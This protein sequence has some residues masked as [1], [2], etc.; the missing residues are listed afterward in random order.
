MSINLF[1]SL[2]FKKEDFL[3]Y[4]IETIPIEFN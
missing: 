1:G 4:L 3:Q 2:A